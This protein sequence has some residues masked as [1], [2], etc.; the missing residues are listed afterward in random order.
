M[1]VSGH[2]ESWLEVGEGE[3]Q[4]HFGLV[5]FLF[6]PFI[7]NLIDVRKLGGNQICRWCDTGISLKTSE[8]ASPEP[9]SSVK[10]DN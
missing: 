10:C 9:R 5:C 1:R 8:P 7:N 2:E 3:E 6:F 4:E